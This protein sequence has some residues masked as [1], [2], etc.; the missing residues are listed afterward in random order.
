MSKVNIAQS[1][2]KSDNIG[3]VNQAPEYEKFM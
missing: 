3:K 2:I 1:M